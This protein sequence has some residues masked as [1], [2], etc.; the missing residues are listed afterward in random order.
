MGK[1]IVKEYDNDITI[2]KYFPY[3]GAPCLV[4]EALATTVGAHKIVK[5]GT[6][7]P[8]NDSTCLGIIL[9]DVDVT[10]GDAPATYVFE[11]CIDTAKAKANSDVTVSAE[12]KAKMP[13]VTWF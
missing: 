4:T 13:R 8:A 7:F 6:P 5:A 11:G 12:A 9:K 1:A 10:N 3:L 2:L